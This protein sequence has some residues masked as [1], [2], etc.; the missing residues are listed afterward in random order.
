V[1]S[2]CPKAR[3]WP[4]WS[5]SG[6]I[7]YVG[8]DNNIY[9]ID[10]SGGNLQ[11]IT[12]DAKVGEQLY[13]MPTWQPGGDKLAYIGI[14]TPP[15]GGAE[16][17]IYSA[18]GGAETSEVYRSDSYLPFYLYW[19]PDG[20]WLSFLTSPG[21]GQ[22]PLALQMAPAEGGEVALL[23]TGRP[24]YWAWSPRERTLLVHSGGSAQTN[25]GSAKV[26]FWTPGQVVETG[27]FL[28]VSG[29]ACSPTVPMLWPA[30]TIRKQVRCWRLARRTGVDRGGVPGRVGFGAPTVIAAFVVGHPDGR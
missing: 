19:S 23:D 3:C 27:G 28:G 8:A 10:Q 12:E 29:P 5:K 2:S 30:K 16:G 7:A 14:S 20:Q 1:E 26:A 24:Y 18:A 21:S 17:T 22:V 13:D 25:P 11:A 15:T 6:L 9:T 4:R